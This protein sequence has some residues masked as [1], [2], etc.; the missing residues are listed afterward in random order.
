MSS[1]DTQPNISWVEWLA[2]MADTTTAAA[3][4]ALQENK[5]IIQETAQRI[6][7]GAFGLMAA[8]TAMGSNEDSQKMAAM[9][10]A[11]A[12]ILAK[13]AEQTHATYQGMQKPVDMFSGL[14]EELKNLPESK[15]GFISSVMGSTGKEKFNTL[16]TAIMTLYTMYYL[17]MVFSPENVQEKGFLGTMFDNSHELSF[18]SVSAKTLSQSIFDGAYK[19]YLACN[20]GHIAAGA[21]SAL[22]KLY[23]IFAKTHSYIMDDTIKASMKGAGSAALAA[24]NVGVGKEAMFLYCAQWYEKEGNVKN[25]EKW[26]KEAAA[27]GSHEAKEWL[28]KDRSNEGDA[29]QGTHHSRGHSEG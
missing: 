24:I 2:K 13:I 19:I 11:I 23:K 21:D 29:I 25:A 20:D 8:K 5:P 1:P 26:Y 7:T 16:S 18:M 15:D 6:A 9:G 3:K 28:K 17:K 4:K 12:G 14:C 10:L 22:D 27:I